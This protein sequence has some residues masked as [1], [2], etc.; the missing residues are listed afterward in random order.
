MADR[1]LTKIVH[2]LTSPSATAAW[3]WLLMTVRRF[4]SPDRRSHLGKVESI[5]VIRLDAI[6]DVLLTG[7]FL[8][9]LRRG[10][11]RA[12]ITLVVA[13]R[14]LNLVETCPYVDRALTHHVPPATRWWHPLSRRLIALSFA[15]R[16]LWPELYDMAVVPRWGEDH[17]EATILA[18]LSG[19]PDRIGYAAR[20][21]GPQREHGRDDRF[22]TRVV[23]DRSVKHE[24]QRN[25]DLLSEMG[26]PAS[27]PEH[28][29][30]VWLTDEDRSLAKRIV[31]S[32]NA[33]KLVAL[34]PGAG[35]PKRMWPI[36]RMEE[37]GRWLADGG[38]RLVVVGGP[39]DEG[40][41]EHLSRRIGDEV[42][43]LTNRATIRETAAV[44]A[45]C[46]LFCGN[47]SGPMHLAAAVG[48]PIVE[49]SCHPLLGDELYPNSPN[50]FGPWGVPCRVAQPD[51]PKEGCA[52]GCRVPSPHCILNVRVD[53]VIAAIESLRIETSV[54][55]GSA[56]AS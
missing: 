39:G 56:N 38:A 45:Q 47:D 46:S 28:R 9:E 11:P 44:L 23:D 54:I 17:Y 48:V 52:V 42:I 26:V 20:S 30:E 7:P 25:V 50:R 21:K 29:L 13:P 36:E 31:T 16:E 27:S 15:R 6:G 5:L 8:R 1:L 37:V 24:V 3:I 4:L 35:S 22:L 12:R 43:D 10:Y 19:A 14:V 32:S 51:M 41:G 53:S 40:L 34:G 55:E 33:A 49:I 2:A 18:R